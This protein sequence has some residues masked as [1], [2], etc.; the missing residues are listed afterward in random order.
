MENDSLITKIQILIGSII[1]VILVVGAFIIDKE[2]SWG[3]EKI[4]SCIIVSIYAFFFIP[5]LKY[6]INWFKTLSIE[7]AFYAG[8]RIGYYGLIGLIIIDPIVGLMYY[9][10]KRFK[11]NKNNGNNIII[12]G[13]YL[14]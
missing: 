4:I 1:L 11:K 8:Y 7:E 9:F 6:I 2:V 3:L 5:M 14:V 13:W 12:V 10:N